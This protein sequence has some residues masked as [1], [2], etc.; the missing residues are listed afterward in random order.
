[1]IISRVDKSEA[2][3]WNS[4]TSIKASKL[5]QT[6]QKIGPNMFLK[7]MAGDMLHAQT[8]YY[9][10]GTVDNTGVGNLFTPLLN[11]VIGALSGNVQATG[12]VKDAATNINSNFSTNPGDLNTYLNNQDQGS[13]TPQAY[14]NILFFDENFRF[15]AYDN[16]TGLGSYGWR[17][18]NSGDNQSLVVPNVK[19]PKNG[20]AYIYLSN[21]SKTA[22]FFDNF[23]V[24]HVRGKIIEE[25]A[26]YPYGLK[27]KGICAK[28]FDKPDSRFDYQGSFSEEEVETGWEEFDLRMYDPQIGRWTGID[29][30]D[31]FSSPYIGMGVNPVNLVDPDG[32]SILNFFGSQAMNHMADIV[33]GAAIGALV[34]QLTHGDAKEGLLWGAG[35]G[36]I[37]SFTPWDKVG[38]FIGDRLPRFET[39]NASQQIPYDVS[40]L[41][42][43][44]L[45][46]LT[47]ELYAI[48]G[49]DFTR[50]NNGFLEYK[51]TRFVMT[52][53]RQEA[54]Q[55]PPSIISS[56]P[57]SNKDGT[58]GIARR[59]LTG[60]AAHS[61]DRPVEVYQGDVAPIDP[62]INSG[63]KPFWIQLHPADWINT[64]YFNVVKTTWGIGMTFLHEMGH[65]YYAGLREDPGKPANEQYY[66]SNEKIKIGSNEIF[67]NRIR[68]Q[69]GSGWGQRL[70]Y[71]DFGRERYMPFNK[72]ALND[73]KNGRIPIGHQYIQ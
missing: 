33:V 32:G 43:S 39:I 62:F 47:Y 16:V 26:Y 72:K 56:R 27:I 31:Q 59:L 13:S 28:A 37:V 21:E 40:R 68:R 69:L 44:M 73:L 2:A 3:G 42:A 61:N 19:V 22:V 25:N 49:L 23:V 9:Y 53:R 15:V 8:D 1:V 58:S 54:K 36:A 4:N 55:R 71:H 12:S 57:I 30:Y 24:N 38:K 67:M 17:V 45:A 20:Y 35:I 52:T 51:E 5:I 29:P 65:T 48:S 70:S 11:S 63:A 66:T 41:S 10:T 64:R 18:A 50:N 46:N 60:T 6:G 34:T 7:V 14:L